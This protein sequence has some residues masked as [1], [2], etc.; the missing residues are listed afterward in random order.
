MSLTKNVSIVSARRAALE[1][2]VKVLREGLPLE[3]PAIAEDAKLTYLPCPEKKH[4]YRTDPAQPEFLKQVNAN[5]AVFV[6]A[7]NS[8]EFGEHGTEGLSTYRQNSDLRIDVLLLFRRPLMD[9]SFELTS[10]P[11]E[12]RLNHEF[13][14]MWLRAQTYSGALLH[15]ICKYGRDGSSVHE[16][17]P[18]GDDAQPI[19]DNEGTW[20]IYGSAWASFEV[21][22]KLSMPN[23][24][25][26]PT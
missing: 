26:L 18:L 17:W 23:P 25:F 24:T 15:T 8:R 14:R 12:V 19:L 5:V 1:R 13:E 11:E 4:I 21:M 6:W 20:P 22:Q 9:P 16:I 10:A 2:I 3:L 7:E